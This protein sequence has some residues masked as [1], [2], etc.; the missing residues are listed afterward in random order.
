LIG[1]FSIK[2]VDPKS[3]RGYAQEVSTHTQAAWWIKTGRVDAA[4]GLQAAAHEAALDFLPLF[5]ERYDLV[6]PCRQR[7]H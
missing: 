7:R 2:G 3:I 1:R 6:S 5:E 4:I